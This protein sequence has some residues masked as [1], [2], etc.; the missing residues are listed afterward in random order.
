VSETSD[1]EELLGGRPRN[2]EPN[3]ETTFLSLL[4]N[5]S[6]NVA[7][8][9]LADGTALRLMGETELS[10]LQDAQ[11]TLWNFLMG[12][13]EGSRRFAVEVSVVEED[14]AK[15]ARAAR[16]RADHV[17]L[18][19]RLVQPGSI[20]RGG[21]YAYQP[22]APGSVSSVPWF[23]VDEFGAKLSPSTFKLKSEDVPLF[24]SIYEGLNRQLSQAAEVAFR[25]FRLADRREHAADRLIDYWIALESLFAKSGETQELRF[26][27]GLRIAHYVGSSRELRLSWFDKMM[28]AYNV[29]S[30]V[31]HGEGTTKGIEQASVD[32]E[33][34]LREALKRAAL[35]GVLPQPDELDRRAAAGLN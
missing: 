22:H 8:I 29:R 4:P 5:F 32:A 30:K 23:D 12:G 18:A 25:R 19:L 24:R 13:G 15:A 35:E 17:V 28:D 11:E 3:H 16:S 1:L 6:T 27:F 20:S 26:K 21:T 9:L 2:W 14:F 33:G 31:V 10:G 7:K 34:A